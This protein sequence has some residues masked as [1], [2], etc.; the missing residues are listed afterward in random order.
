MVTQAQL[1][2]GD[3]VQIGSHLLSYDGQTLLRFDSYGYRLDV[4]DLYKEVKTKNGPLRIL[5]D[6]SLTIMP[7]EFVALVG[8]S[9]AGKST[10]LDALNGFRPAQG[11]VLINGQELYENYDAFRAQI[12]YVPQSEIL[13]TSLTVEAALQYAARLRLAADLSAQERQERITK[14]LATVEMNT[15]RIRQTRIGRLSGGQRKRVSIAAELLADPKIFF[16]DEPASGLDPGLEKKLMV[17]LRKM[18]DEGRTDEIYLP[19]GN[20]SEDLLRFWGILVGMGAALGLATVG[21]VK[22]LDY[23]KT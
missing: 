14:A 15:E 7:R 22:R 3:Q 21:M 4:V 11:Q 23:R 17:T 10:L 9:G 6:I 5:D 16:L 2:V 19:Y 1:K 13:P 20:H 18:A 8:G 12:G